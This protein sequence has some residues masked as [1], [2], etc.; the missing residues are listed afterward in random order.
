MFDLKS[1][2]RF[3]VERHVYPLTVVSVK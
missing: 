3:R 1:G 2:E